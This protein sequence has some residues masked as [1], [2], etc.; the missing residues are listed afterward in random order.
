MKIKFYLLTVLYNAI[1]LFLFSDGVYPY[2]NSKITPE[3]ILL[4]LQSIFKEI[5]D[6][7]VQLH[8]EIDMEDIN[9]PPMDV[10][11][12]FKQPDKIHLHSKG[13]AMLPR[14]GMFI[15]PGRFTKENFYVSLIGID[16]VKNIETY[17]MELVPRREEIMTRKFIIWID[18][19]KWIILKMH[20]ISWQGQSAQISFE[21]TKIENKYWLPQ[22]TIADISLTG[23]KG[24]SNMME[25]PGREDKKADNV[26]TK[27]G[28]ITI[29]FFKYKINTGLSDSIFE[30][31]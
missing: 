29:H 28:K 27:K 21:Y 3:E 26:S 15:N 25:M 24:F 20:T 7:T 11:V 2:Q 12:Y 1:F 5:K 14:E 4:H 19:I 13:F 8:A 6:Y 31:E 18:P 17:K 10:T 16:T 23:F 22:S 30:G 9:V